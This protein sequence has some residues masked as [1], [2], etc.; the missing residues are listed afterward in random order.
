[1]LGMGKGEKGAPLRGGA[2]E[3]VWESPSPLSPF[4]GSAFSPAVNPPLRRAAAATSFNARPPPAAPPPPPPPVV[5]SDLSS[6]CN[7]DHCRAP[8]S[9]SSSKWEVRSSS[10]TLSAELRVSESSAPG[11]SEDVGGGWVG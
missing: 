9:S 1:M 6:G 3:G 4:L 5:S 2:E 11:W 8:A 10:P 7:F